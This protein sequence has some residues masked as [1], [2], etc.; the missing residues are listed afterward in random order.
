MKSCLESLSVR[1]S[2]D[3][4]KVDTANFNASRI[5][6]L[7][8][9]ISRKGDNTADRPHR[10]SRI[11]SAPKEPDVISLEDLKRL[12]LLFP[13]EAPPQPRAQN[14]KNDG[15]PIDLA[16]WFTRNGIGYE[17]KPYLDGTL[18]ILDE[19]PFSSAHKDGAYAIPILKRGDICFMSSRLLRSWNAEMGRASGPV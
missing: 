14:R 3:R 13:K 17:S 11:I 1:F 6:K 18:F 2:D 5:W 9:T 16:E 10:Q 15:K 19:C 8:G 4:C 12:S 7:Y